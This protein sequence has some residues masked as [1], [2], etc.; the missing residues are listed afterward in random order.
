MRRNI[1]D[2]ALASG[3]VMGPMTLGEVQRRLDS[4]N[5]SRLLTPF[6]EEE[7]RHYAELLEAESRLMAHQSQQ[8]S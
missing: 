2:M 7:R 1:K 8:R 4:M 5:K 6:N 3:P